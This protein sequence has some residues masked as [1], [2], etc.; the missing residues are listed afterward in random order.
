[1]KCLRIVASVFSVFFPSHLALLPLRFHILLRTLKSE[2]IMNSFWNFTNW[3]MR[4]Y[5]IL[6]P[7]TGR[8]EAASW[9]VEHCVFRAKLRQEELNS[10]LIEMR[11]WEETLEL[12]EDECYTGGFF[13]IKGLFC[14][15][16]SW[17]KNTK[18]GI[19]TASSDP[20]YPEDT[21]WTICFNF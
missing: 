18:R 2:K 1:M 19:T 16:Q 13:L 8:T 17:F 5:E 14:I 3:L 21:A 4:A 10:S 15:F 12:Y 20:L 11:Y 6:I 9:F 7:S